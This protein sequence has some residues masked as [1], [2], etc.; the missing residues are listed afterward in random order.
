MEFK[1]MTTQDILEVA[2][3]YNELA[4]YIKNETEDEYFDFDTLSESELESILDNSIK[5]PE[6]ITFVAREC[7]KVI[8]FISG[9]IRDCFLPISKTKKVGYISGAY[10]LPNYRKKGIMK[11]L[12]GLL[13]EYFTSKGLCYIELNVIANNII[14]KKSWEVMGY[15]TFREQMRKK[16]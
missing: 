4:Y 10:V 9:E 7:G 3:L 15:K 1:E 12:E 11:K 8:A 16:I 6:N 2:K 13:L 14:G 5:N